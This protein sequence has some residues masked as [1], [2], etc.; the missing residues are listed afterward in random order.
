M[1]GSEM[2]R[3]GWVRC[4]TKS[5]HV[6]VATALLLLAGFAQALGPMR[7][8][9]AEAGLRMWRVD[10]EDRFGAPV[11]RVLVGVSLAR[12]L[13]DNISVGVE[14]ASFLEGTPADSLV[15]DVRPRLY[16]FPLSRITPWTELRAG[17]ALG[18]AL[19]NAVRYGGGFGLRW[20]PG[21]CSDALALDLQIVGFERW[22]QDWAT[23]Y[24]DEDKPSGRIDWTMS[25]TPWA[26]AS[27]GVYGRSSPLTWPV[28][29]VT[30]LF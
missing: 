11:G 21:C 23:E 20:V 26:S 4:K 13:N 5:V 1:A 17:G 12:F 29:G 18:L 25:R 19:G 24:V 10:R 15:L 27:S 6:R 7:T 9:M 22:K 16:W 30:W 8:G 3:S 28:L 14:V 2:I